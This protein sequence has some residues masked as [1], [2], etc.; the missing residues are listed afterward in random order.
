MLLKIARATTRALTA[1]VLADVTIFGLAEPA[2][3]AEPSILPLARA[4]PKI[5]QGGI[6]T[7]LAKHNATRDEVRVGHLSWDNTLATH[8]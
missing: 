3:A 7:I 8:A 2:M 5:D 1:N 6:N 4:A